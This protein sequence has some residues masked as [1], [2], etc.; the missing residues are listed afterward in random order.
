MSGL[1]AR[2]FIVPAA[3]AAVALGAAGTALAITT[4]TSS[5]PHVVSVSMAGRTQA[6]LKITGGTPLLEVS[7]AH[8]AG[9]LLRV[10]TPDDAP[11]R[12]VLSGSPTIVLSLAGAAASGTGNDG[13]AY[14]VKVVLNSAVVWSIDF[15]GGTERTQADLRGGKIGGI[16]VTAGSDIL[17]IALPGPAGTLPFL[18]A[19]GVTQFRVSL[20]G[21]VLTQITVGGGASHV[22]I[23]GQSETG[24]AGGT[25][26]TPAGWATATS[27]LNIDATAG[28]SSLT[29]SRW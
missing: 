18:L 25:V 16:A 21:G 12:P 28:F 6:A 5:S 23:G 11:V 4:S 19:G 24:V 27:R 9:T 1:I 20:P 3:I 15:A 29:V 26:L 8:L 17:D 10:S 13:G 22:T 14:A 2:R 7:V